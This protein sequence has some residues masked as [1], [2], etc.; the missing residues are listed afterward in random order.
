MHGRYPA[1]FDW[2]GHIIWLKIINIITITH[3][4]YFSLICVSCIVASMLEHESIQGVLGSKPT[5]LRKRSTSYPEEGVTIEV[6]L[7]RISQFHTTMSQHGIDPDLIKQVVKQ[8]FYNICAV[9]LNHLLLRKDMCSWSKGLQ[10][11]YS[12][13]CSLECCY[14][15][16]YSKTIGTEEFG[17]RNW[18]QASFLRLY[19]TPTSMIA[20]KPPG[21]Y[22]LSIYCVRLDGES[23][24]LKL[25]KP[26]IMC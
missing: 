15:T 19:Q 9:T 16:S 6:L 17:L 14:Y 12:T 21:N 22:S 3:E 18:Y 4:I 10:I 26:Q 24:Y 5:G 2:W 8:Q 11:R 23:Q 1:A 25:K 20:M 7:Q 13:K